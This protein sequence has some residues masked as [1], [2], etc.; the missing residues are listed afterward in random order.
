MVAATFLDGHA[1]FAI[2]QEA[3]VTFTA[4]S[5]PF[6]ALLG[7]TES[8]A[9]QGASVCTDLIV[10]VRGALHCCKEKMPI[11]EQGGQG[12]LPLLYPNLPHPSS[13]SCY[14]R[15]KV[16]VLHGSTC[17]PAAWQALT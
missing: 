17:P 11:R 5:T 9:A 6:W 10:A 12:I 16:S 8:P 14:S 13:M 2:V 7:C 15:Q 3:R 1:D 4:L